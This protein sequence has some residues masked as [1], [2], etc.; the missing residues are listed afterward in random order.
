MKD[1]TTDNPVFSESIKILETTDPGHADMVNVTTQQLLENTLFLYQELRER[2][3]AVLSGIASDLEAYYTSEEVDAKISVIPKFKIEVVDTLPAS[4]IS[5]ATV[6]LLKSGEE[7]QNLYTEYI[8]VNGAWEKLGTQKVDLSGYSTKADTV[9]GAA[10]K[11]AKTITFT[12]GDGTTFDITVTG[13]TYGNMKG[14]T[15]SAAGG[16]GLVPAPAAGAANR[17]L[18]CDGQWGV[19]P[20]TNTTYGN[21]RGA[22]ASAAGAAGLVPAPPAGAQGKFFRGDGTYQAIENSGV[23]ASATAPSNTNL[24]WIDTSK[25]GITKYYDAS[26]KT[27]KTTV[28]V[29]G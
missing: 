12:R 4:E 5:E 25:G 1:Y 7:S 22:T 3:E 13:T 23:L 21:M 17:Y 2:I 9:K 28:A 16:A 24:L 27:W 20:D 11:D 26:S 29:W 19:P 15:A 8:R 18:R 14:A 6:Y 10:M